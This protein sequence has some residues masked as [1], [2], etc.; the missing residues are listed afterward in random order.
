[1]FLV[2]WSTKWVFSRLVGGNT[3]L[4]VYGLGLLE[5]SMLGVMGVLVVFLGIFPGLVYVL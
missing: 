3:K 5:F 1:M 4:L 2:L